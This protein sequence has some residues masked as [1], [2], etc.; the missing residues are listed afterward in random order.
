MIVKEEPKEDTQT[1]TEGALLPVYVEI[2]HTK[3]I[4]F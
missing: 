2:L 3:H 4:V 1:I